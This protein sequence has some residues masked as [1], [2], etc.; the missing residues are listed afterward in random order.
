MLDLIGA[1][2]GMSAVAINLVA[3]THALPGTLGRRL[4]LAVIAGAWVRSSPD[5]PCVSR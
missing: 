1:I 3:L 2:V 4:A 5:E